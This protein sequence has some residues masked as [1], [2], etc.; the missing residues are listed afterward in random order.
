M[1][2]RYII[3]EILANEVVEI[4]HDITGGNV[5]VMDGNGII[6]ATKQKHRLGKLHEGAKKIVEGKADFVA[7]TENEAAN[8]EGVMPG[9]N[10]PIKIDGERIGCIGITGKPKDTEPLQKLA[11][12]IVTNEIKKDRQINRE[13]AI[14]ESIASKINKTYDAISKVSNGAKAIAKTNKNME[15]LSQNVELRINDINKVLKLINHIV[16][17]TNLLGINAAI[18]AAR[19]GKYGRGFSVVAEEVRKLSI[20]SSNSLKS[21]KNV[22]S[23]IR[24]V[25]CSIA[26]GIHK[27]FQNTLEQAKATKDIENSIYEI[28]LKLDKFH[29]TNKELNILRRSYYYN[30]NV[31]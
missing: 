21:I 14:V 27:N 24:N 25:V 13:R 7:V 4:L 19:A 15:E 23:E 9:Y 22:L 17:Q 29:K 12:I 30:D 11:S 18:E 2:K 10:G 16:D 3:P 28:Q 1:S 5:N 31:I 6:I 20:E 26:Q 8:M